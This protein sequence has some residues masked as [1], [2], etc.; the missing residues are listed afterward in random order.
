MIMKTGH[1]QKEIMNI[2]LHCNSCR[3]FD[4]YGM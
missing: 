4:Q 3:H 2:A 1:V